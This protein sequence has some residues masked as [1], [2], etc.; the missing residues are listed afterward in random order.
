MNEFGEFRDDNFQKLQKVLGKGGDGGQEGKGKR[1]GGGGGGKPTGASAAQDLRKI[2]MLIKERKL[3]PVIVFSFSRRCGAPGGKCAA[4][5]ACHHRTVAKH[6]LPWTKP[7]LTITSHTP[8]G[9]A[10]PMPC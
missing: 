8:T 6:P 7:A 5:S 1:G 9:S 2:V 10:N 4:M 3:D